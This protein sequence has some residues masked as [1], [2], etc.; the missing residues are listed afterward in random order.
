MAPGLAIPGLSSSGLYALGFALQP[1]DI[2]YINFLFGS[3]VL[4]YY[5]SVAINTFPKN[6]IT[7]IRL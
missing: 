1:E 5:I 3:K 2:T 7:R 6:S 4:N